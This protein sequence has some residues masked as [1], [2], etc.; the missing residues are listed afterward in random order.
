MLLAAARLSKQADPCPCRVSEDCGTRESW[1]Y[2]GWG[3][4][5]RLPCFRRLGKRRSDIVPET[6]Q[7][8]L[9]AAH[10]GTCASAFWVC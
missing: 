5:D 9:L 7:Q 4:V 2:Q 8:R 3:Y 1:G 10:N 6:G